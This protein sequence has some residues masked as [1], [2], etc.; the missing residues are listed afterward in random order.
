[1]AKY[2]YNAGGWEEYQRDMRR[3]RNKFIAHSEISRLNYSVPFMDMALNAAFLYD[4]WTGEI[5]A[6][7]WNENELFEDRI[8]GWTR[9][10]NATLNDLIG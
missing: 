1:M 9:E 6:P 10:I 3:F 4:R 2:Q 8:I 7:D 5:M